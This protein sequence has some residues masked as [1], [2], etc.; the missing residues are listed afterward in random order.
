M[1]MSTITGELGAAAVIFDMDG[2]LADTRAFHERS[3]E[4]LHR[5]HGDGDPPPREILVRTFGQT[6]DT[7]IPLLFGP[8][9]DIPRLSEEKESIYREEARGKVRPTPGVEAFIMDLRGRGIRTGIGTSGLPENVSFLLSEFHW[10]G[11]FD[12]VV[13]RTGFERSKPAPD[14]FARVAELLA[15]DPRRCVVFEDSI[16][17]IEAAQAARMAAIGV[18]GTNDAETLLRWTPYVID[19]FRVFMAD[20]GEEA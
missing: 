11:L 1:R 3:W 12:A 17:G 16:P 4:I 10:E 20:T 19:D 9:D 8:G 7:I 18:T 14:C 13:D 6:N 15:V 5:R 2:V